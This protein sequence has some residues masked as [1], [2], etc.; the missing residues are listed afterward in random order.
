MENLAVTLGSTTLLCNI[1]GK[2]SGG[3]G[4]KWMLHKRV[5]EPSVT[6]RFSIVS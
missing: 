4:A 3:G 1:M 5:V 2:T 6:V